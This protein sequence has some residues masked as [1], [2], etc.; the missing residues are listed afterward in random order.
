MLYVNN[1]MTPKIYVSN[2]VDTMNDFIDW[3]DGTFLVDNQ[4][5]VFP[6][7]GQKDLDYKKGWIFYSDT[8]GNHIGWKCKFRDKLMKVIYS[9]QLQKFNCELTFLNF[10]LKI[11]WEQKV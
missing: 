8:E 2:A 7:C 4:K 10:D 6:L 5:F 1:T 9:E 11:K 3:K